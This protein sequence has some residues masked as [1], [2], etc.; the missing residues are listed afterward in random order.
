MIGES[1]MSKQ[2]T[3]TD[4]AKACNTSNVTVSNA[5]AD[6]RGV[7]EELR[8]KIKETAKMMGYVSTHSDAQKKGRNMVGV[9]IPEK[10]MYP[11]GSFY[12][13]LYNSLVSRFQERELYCLIST[14][15]EE[16]ENGLILPK[17]ITDGMVSSVISLGQLNRNY[18]DKLKETEL[19]M[20]LL[21]H[22]YADSG[23][24]SVISNGYLGGYELT[25]YLIS[26][27]HKNIGYVGTVKATSSIFDRYM[28]YSRAMIEHGLEVRPEW[29]IDDR[30]EHGNTDLF[31]TTPYPTAFVCNCD[32]TAYQ[33]INK[34]ETLGVEVPKD[35]SVVGYDNYLISDLSK[36]TI[37]TINVDY[38]LMAKKAVEV[39]CQR[40]YDPDRPV[41]TVTISGELI[42]KGS[43]KAL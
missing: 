35:I 40:I 1:H 12:W 33:A 21:D 3:L 39:L 38:D 22:Y 20:I 27:G 23:V 24:D 29:T 15:S 43:V 18:V 4:I 2:I 9:I 17:C 28:G 31:F 16:D 42:V 6:K 41:Q 37:T 13:A 8:K 5:L 36:P 11:K 10:F 7:S 30:D 19:P 14:L 34:L 25:A 26:Q 32:E